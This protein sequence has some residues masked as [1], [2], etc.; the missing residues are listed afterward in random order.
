MFI[1]ECQRDLFLVQYIQS[2][3]SLSRKIVNEYISYW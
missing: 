2:L 3:S 1:L